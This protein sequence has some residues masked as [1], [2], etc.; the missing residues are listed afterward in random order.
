MRRFHLRFALVVLSLCTALLSGCLLP[1][2]VKGPMNSVT[3][4]L[5]CTPKPPTL[6]VLLPGAYDKPQDFIDQGFVAAVR[7]RNIYAD[8]QLVDAHTGYYTNQ[9]IVQRL[10]EEVV[11]PA[12]EQGYVN[13][14][15]AGISLGGYG[16]LLYS[17]NQ[18]QALE[19]IFLMAPFMGPRDIPAEI[20]RLG[21][22]KQWT[23]TLSIQESIDTQL[24]RSLRNYA[25]P[26]AR[27]PTTYL[28]YGASDRFAKP[29]ALL[30]EVLPSERSFVIPGGHDW[31]T[32]QQLWASFLDAASLPR[33]DVANTTC[34][35][36]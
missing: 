8:I 19:G 29:S 10:E 15:F 4:L 24:W 14:W 7:K 21:G 30:A 27:L 26:K 3:D 28:G 11:K 22:L 32:W 13:I 23:G 31:A 12:R 36:L 5:N 33:I 18:P 20:A 16:S 25:A 9:Q 6:I 2:S 35:T 34:K 1:R 17:M